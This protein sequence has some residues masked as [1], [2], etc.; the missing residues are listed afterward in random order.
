MCTLQSE[1]LTKEEKEQIFE[2]ANKISMILRALDER[3]NRHRQLVPDRYKKLL[4]NLKHS[5]RI[6]ILYDH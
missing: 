4:E 3:M 6:S 5:R 2:K 1:G